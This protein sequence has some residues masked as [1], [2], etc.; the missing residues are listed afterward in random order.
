MNI[1]WP[2][3]TLGR[4]RPNGRIPKTGASGRVCRAS[5]QA[6]QWY[7]RLE[8]IWRCI[9]WFFFFSDS[10][11]KEVKENERRIN[12]LKKLVSSRVA[13]VCRHNDTPPSVIVTQVVRASV[14]DRFLP[15]SFR[16]PSWRATVGP[17]LRRLASLAIF[18]NGIVSKQLAPRCVLCKTCTQAP[19]RFLFN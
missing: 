1:K 3:D 12:R 14:V 7:N 11:E 10:K 16:V 13:C 17:H 2:N 15:V 4:K 8:C 19:D 6:T 5:Q 9:W 18:V